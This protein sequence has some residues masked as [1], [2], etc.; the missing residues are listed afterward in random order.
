MTDHLCAACRACGCANTLRA[1]VERV[2]RDRDVARWHVREL[3][4]LIE[5]LRQRSDAAHTAEHL[6]TNSDAERTALRGDAT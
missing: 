5:D 6:M 4:L 1:K 3:R 2:E